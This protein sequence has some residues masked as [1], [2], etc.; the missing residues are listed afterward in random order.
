MADVPS[1]WLPVATLEELRS[2]GVMVVRGAD[3]PIA[4]YPHEE[5]AAAVDNRCPHLGFPLHRGSV[6][7]GILTCHWHHARFDLCSGCTFDLFADDVPAY[8]TEIREG[9]VFVAARPRHRDPVTHHRGRLRQGLEQNIGLIQAKAL[10]GLQS[11]GRPA[12]EAVEEIARFGLRYRD[13]WASGMTILTAMANLVPHLAPETSYLALSQGSRRVAADCAG[14]TPRRDRHP[15]E[16]DRIEAET[17]KRWLRYWITVR[18]RD[19]AER[20]LLTAIHAREES[21]VVAEL[22]FSAATERFY[23]DTG[24]ALDFCNK[25][26]ELLDLLG[27]DEAGWVLPT[28]MAQIAAARGGE[29][30]NSWRHPVDLVPA[31]RACEAA[32]PELLTAGEGKT[33]TA[34]SALADA[35]LSDDPLAN[36]EALRT[37]LREGARPEQCGKALALAAALR[38]AR[39]GTAN[40]FGDWITALH[41]FT[42]CSALHQALRR[43]PSAEVCRGLFHGAIS[44]YLDRFLNVPPARLPG[45]REC[46]GEPRDPEALLD[47]FLTA[48]DRQQSV[49]AAARAVARYLQLGHPVQPL[50]DTLTRSVVREDADFHTFQMVEAAVRQYAGWEG[51]PEGHAILV[52][53]A[54]YLAAHAP[55]QRAQLQTAQIALRLHRGESLFEEEA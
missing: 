42:Y 45:E 50:F 34:E 51:Q 6:Q 38:I 14:M 17:L 55:T 15:L 21:R 46:A 5:G 26:C 29:E 37:A 18:Q 8:D 11:A 22:V 13:G 3:R 43:C 32:L 9:Q 7:D 24:H 30:L 47:R 48:L 35:L 19:G 25:A 54:R 44:V 10:L 2:R 33:W 4:V 36:L 39:F 40:E 28:V 41:T 53:A 1:D 12:T 16:T 31:V 52:A 27:W 49:E 23:A 20:T